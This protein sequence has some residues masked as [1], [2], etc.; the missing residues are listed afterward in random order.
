VKL[1]EWL[2]NEWVK[3][4]IMIAIILIAFFAFWFG[5]R[6]SLATEYPLLAVASESMVPTLNVGDLIVV[7]GVSNPAE[8]YAHPVNGDIIIFTTY[9]PSKTQEPLDLWPGKEPELIVHR[10]IN[11]TLKWDDHVGRTV[12]YFTTKGDHNPSEDRWPGTNFDGVPD[13]YV[14]GK[15]VGSVPQLGNVP[16]FI[17]T[18]T[19]VITI[20]ALIIIVLMVD[21]LY[22]SYRE[23]RRPPPNEGVVQKS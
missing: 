20:V 22:S 19:G 11:K 2:K 14:V 6:Y 23:K 5:L 17:R 10:A 7:H 15:V 18:P 1:R 13:Y 9:D 8:I 21:L 12:W 3:T 16:L 4:G